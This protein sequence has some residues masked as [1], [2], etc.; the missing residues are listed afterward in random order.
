MSLML[1]EIME[2]PEVLGR[3]YET[4][5]ACI[6]ALVEELGA[7]GITKAVFA[8]RG[9]SDNAAIYAQYMLG[10]YRGVVSALAIPSSMSAYG[11]TMHFEDCLV[12]G[13][14]QSGRATD[15][16][17]VLSQAK[18]NG[19]PT[20]AI[21]NDIS[22]PMA[23]VAQY[24]LFCDA[25]EEKS[26]AATKTFTAQ[27]YLAACLAAGWGA[28][29]DLF[30]ALER[31][32]AQLGD[33]L[34]SVPDAVSRMV[35]RFRYA[36][37]GFVL[38]RGFNYPVAL[39]MALKLNETCYM[40]IKGYAVS[41]FY[42]GPLAQIDENTP[43]ILLAPRGAL[44][45]DIRALAKRIASCGVRINMITDDAALAE[46]YPDGVLL[47]HT[48]FEATS[49]FL[50]AAFAQIFAEKLS[51]SRGLNPDEPRNLKKVTLTL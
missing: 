27:M 51:I 23:K 44:C 1:R 8:G 5:R 10:V 39:E 31:V 32:P 2:Q 22:S 34:T 20:L 19:A 43:V 29:E 28:N 3:V 7:R 48:G 50:F 35:D 40:K 41:D 6:A 47:P 9:T 37:D 12:T 45:E 26:V 24:H 49:T 4:N 30:R 46:E 25:G 15:A 33:F 16:L 38:S 13:I 17:Y 14:S 36:D 21:T 42:H 18:A 11:A